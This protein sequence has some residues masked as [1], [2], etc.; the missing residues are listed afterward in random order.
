[1]TVT[2]TKKYGVKKVRRPESMKKTTIILAVV[3][4][5]ILTLPVTLKPVVLSIT[6]KQLSA[7]F[8]DSVVSIQDC[9]I[10][11]VHTSLTGIEISKEPF[12]RF[13][14]NEVWI[15]YR[16][17][18][19]VRGIVRR[20]SVQDL[21]LEIATPKGK[22]SEFTKLL[23]LEKRK[24]P[25]LIGQVNLQDTSLNI[26]TKDTEITGSFTL[27]FDLLR[28]SPFY[29]AFD[30]NSLNMN[31]LRIEEATLGLAPGTG[32]NCY[33]KRMSYG[34]TKMADIGGKIR[35]AEKSFHLDS[36][37]ARLLGGRISGTL[38]AELDRDFNYTLIL[39]ASQI[40]LDNLVSDFKLSEKF[41]MSGNLQGSF[42]FNG[43]G[44]D[45]KLLKGDFSIIEPGG[46]L[47]ITD[48][49]FLKYLASSSQQS[50]DMITESFKDYNYNTGRAGLFMD[51]GDLS[52]D[53]SLDGAQGKRQL[54]II[55]HD[56][57]LENYFK[58]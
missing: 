8:K 15:S 18:S 5:I 35:F 4:I 45:I 30:I 43:S 25:F 42:K 23:N 21:A 31:G 57:K 33:I 19:L 48:K 14:I 2:K 50:L 12:Y 39:E 34:K 58:K 44:Y 3:L 16:P 46:K 38:D 11:P 32:G 37:S 29:L 1:V 24:S 13:K 55:L 41:Q 52:L 49:E 56:F 51:K 7:I 53:V 27:G 9:R 36:M 17:S 20:V 47:I 10:R 28:K 22:L 40:A 54:D 6:K 26:K